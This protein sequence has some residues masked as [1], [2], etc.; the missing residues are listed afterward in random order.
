MI[1]TPDC[2]LLDEPMTGSTCERLRVLRLLDRLP[3]SSPSSSRRIT[4]RPR[5]CD[6]I[7]ILNAAGR[8]IKNPAQVTARAVGY[9]FDVSLPAN[10]CPRT[11]AGMSCRPS[12][13]EHLRLRVV[14]EAPPDARPVSPC[15][16]DAYVLLT[17]RAERARP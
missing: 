1:H 14:G 8:G 16:T 6:E 9:V 15:L 2:S 7:L 17:S 5:R 10:L 13:G 4:R 12:D 11:L 3:V